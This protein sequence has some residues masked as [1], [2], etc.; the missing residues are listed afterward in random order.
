LDKAF[1]RFKAVADKKKQVYDEDLVAIAEEETKY[2]PD[3]W[4]LKS[5][6]V[7]S[8]TNIAPKA[9]VT[10]SSKGKVYEKVSTGDGPVDACYKAIEAI[11][12]VKGELL[13]YSIQSVTHGKDAL[14]EVTIKARIHGKN[15]IGHGSSTDILEASAKAYLNAINK[16]DFQEA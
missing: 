14:G 16:M 1:V 8:G 4:Q 2:V 7:T 12:K 9:T 5:L 10:L 6:A 15:Y 13:D 11:V 3:T